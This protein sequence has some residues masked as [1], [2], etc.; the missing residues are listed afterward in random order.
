MDLS[1]YNIILIIFYF[2]VVFGIGLWAKRKQTA[3]DYINASRRVGLFQSS[4]SILAIMGGIFLIGQAALSYDLG[5]GVMWFWV[6]LALGLVLLGFMAEKVKKIAD[7]NNLLT[8]SEYILSKYDSKN[9]TLASIILFLAF[10]S[11]LIGQ[12]IAGGSLFAPLLGISYPVAVII[13]GLGT[14]LYLTFGG[15]KAVVKTD[16]L[17][18]LIML[19]V[20]AFLIFNIDLG[21]YSSQQLDLTAV[22]GSFIVSFL[23]VGV[24]VVFGAADIWQRIFAANSIK[25]AKKASYISALI[26]I[27]FGIMLSYVGIAAKNHFPNIN[28]SEAFYYGLFHLLP[29]PL[30][31]LA[32]IAV[33]AA[34]M[35]TIDTELFYLASSATRDFVSKKRQYSQEKLAINIRKIILLLAFTSMVI[36]IF[37]SNILQ[38]IFA[39]IS[40]NLIVSPIIFFSL[41]WKIKKRAVFLGM[42]GGLLAFFAL[43]ISANLNADTIVATLP[44][45]ILFLVAGQLIFRKRNIAVG[46]N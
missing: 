16:L 45:T 41:F 6:G 42:L 10:F 7:K 1:F 22:G 3:G 15:F 28:P 29:A 2:A 17:Q 32:I 34:I 18:F 27:V 33:L 46:Q 36:A 11:V 43:V 21:E 35:S 14:L 12:F 19:F 26:F 37:V 30:L 40:L 38:L 9:A 39:L 5:F 4:A 24:F 44:A 13:L 31:G 23:L 8:I 25:T 20:F